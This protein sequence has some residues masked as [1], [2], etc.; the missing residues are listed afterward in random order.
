MT[1]AMGPEVEPRLGRALKLH[2]GINTGLI[3][4]N[5]RDDRDGRVASQE[6]RSTSA[7]GS[8]PAPRTTRSCSGRRRASWWRTSSNIEPLE[9]VMLKGKAEQIT[10]YR[11][12]AERATPATALQPFIARWA[13]IRQFTAIVEGCLE[14]GWGRTVYVR[15]DA[16]VGKSKLLE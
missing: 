8:S 12:I 10:P 4:T 3:V 5:L 16:G 9:P 7:R 13:E 14:F 2:T 6:I 11:L 1:R 15:A